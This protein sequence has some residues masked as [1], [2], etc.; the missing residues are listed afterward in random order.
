MVFPA[1]Y[2]PCYFLL[3]TSRPG[4]TV[5]L[6]FFADKLL[7]TH[8]DGLSAA[9]LLIDPTVLI[10]SDN[11]IIQINYGFYLLLKTQ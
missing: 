3:L 8:S 2:C 1:L 4:N 10:R 5:D 9:P 6:V 11:E 7:E